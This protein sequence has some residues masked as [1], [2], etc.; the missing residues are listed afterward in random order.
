MGRLLHTVSE[1]A[2]SGVMQIGDFGRLRS[3]GTD[4]ASPLGQLV[5]PLLIDPSKLADDKWLFVACGTYRFYSHA[6]SY[7]SLGSA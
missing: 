1:L 2:G 3:Q 4:G 5:E 6:G 7:R